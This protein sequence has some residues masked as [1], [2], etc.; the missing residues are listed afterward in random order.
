MDNNTAI[1]IAAVIGALGA[2]IAALIVTYKAKIIE[3]KLIDIET[4]QGISGEVFI[5]ADKDGFPSQP[6]SPAVLKVKRGNRVI[7]AESDGYE[8]KIVSVKDVV[9]SRNIEMKKIA[10]AGIAMPLPLSLVGSN[11]WDLRISRDA[12]DNEIIVNGNLGDAGGFFKNG[13]DAILRGK[14]LVLYFSN[15]SNSEFSLNRMVRLT[16]N[17]SDITLS[18]INASPSNGGYIPDSE[19]PLDRG[20]EYPIPNDF[21]GKL[22]FVFYQAN[23][24][25]LKIRAYYK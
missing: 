8:P 3:V 5:D 21:D 1:I 23:L 16:Y 6:G 2:I 12:Q 10:A 7:R 11:P 4:K 19:T 17:R 18:P 15:V 14:T 24:R 13:L 25:D 9:S 20:I 22:G